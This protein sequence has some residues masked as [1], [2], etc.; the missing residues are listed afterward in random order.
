M[1]GWK[2]KTMEPVMTK[3]NTMFFT[4]SLIMEGATEKVLQ[5]VMP[6]KSIYNKN[7]GLNEQLNNYSTLQNYQNNK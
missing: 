7:F 6:L 4:L 3:W 2:K 5:C 1:D